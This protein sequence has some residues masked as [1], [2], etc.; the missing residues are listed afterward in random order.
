MKGAV[1]T[2]HSISTP[3]G[4]PHETPIVGSDG[5]ARLADALV[6]ELDSRLA[7]ADEAL[8]T[9]YPGDKPDRQPV[10]TVYVSAD[11]YREDIVPAWGAAALAVID[12][13]ATLFAEVAG[14]DKLVALVRAKL[15][16]EPIEDLRIDFEDGYGSRGDDVEDAD[17]QAAASGLAA[18]IAGGI[19]AP[20]RGIRFKSLEAPSR[21]RGIR[22]LTM[23]L[24][25][26]LE[27]GGTLDDFVV[28]LPKIT[29]VDQVEAMTELTGRVEESLGLDPRSL[30]FE[31]Q[32]ETPQSILGPDGTAMVARMMHV[33]EGRVTALHY[34]TYDYSAFCGIPAAYQSMSIRSRTTPSW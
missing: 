25:R 33:S 18:A 2:D 21:R 11:L 28:T 10:Q 8:T 20:F 27:D 9:G 23:F 31:L 22:T 7:D 16:A 15:D 12:D 29:S 30:R 32:I 17:V 19:A 26:L 6:S 13:H 4:R 34:G 5:G 3:T 24:S 14:D 1:V